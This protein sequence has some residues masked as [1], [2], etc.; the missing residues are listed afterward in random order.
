MKVVIFAGGLGTRIA[1]ETDTRPKPMVE[2]GGKPMLWHIMKIYSQY[3]FNDFIIC[4]GYKGYLIK[5]YFMHYFLHN[6]DITIELGSNKLD[7]HY[8]NTDPFK[9][10]LVDT[11][12]STKTAGR[13]KKVQQYIGQE[14]FMLTYGD[15]VSDIDLKALEQ[16]HRSHGKIA[17][18]TAI[19]PEARFGGIEL[20]QAGMV[21]SF[22]E[23]PKGDGKWINGGFFILRPE[24]FRYLDGEINDVMWEDAPMES[25]S[26]DGQLMAYR[27][28]G[29]WKCMD[30]MRDKLELESLWKNDQAKW[31]IW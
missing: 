12:L 14:D 5:E 2:I 15:G 1:E 7:V 3:G 8:T 9:V 19:Q 28:K 13:L 20:N 26:R 11:G 27:H 29:F 4:L 25:L 24:V 21:T 10:T 30:A 6:S 23:K 31:K 17:T 22:K 16:F 18:V